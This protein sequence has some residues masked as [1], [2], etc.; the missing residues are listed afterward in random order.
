MGG[1]GVTEPPSPAGSTTPAPAQPAPIVHCQLTVKAHGCFPAGSPKGQPLA[2]FWGGVLIKPFADDKCR[3][4]VFVV[5]YYF[6]FFF[7]PVETKRPLNMKHNLKHSIPEKN[8]L[9]IF[10]APKKK[11]G[12]GKKK[13]EGK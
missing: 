4:G 12:G 7:P 9:I 6:Y 3:V 11:G 10:L 8:F 5:S 13:K 2:V 1:D